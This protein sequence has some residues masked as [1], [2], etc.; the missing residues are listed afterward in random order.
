MREYLLEL[1]AR[2]FDVDES[3]LGDDVRLNEDLDA[4]SL[5]KFMLIAEL[6]EKT[7]KNVKYE[8]LNACRTV[9]E[10]IQF[11]ESLA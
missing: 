10:L 9:G 4:E 6:K 3:E 5:Q 7:G 11:A 8:E 1:L 2:F